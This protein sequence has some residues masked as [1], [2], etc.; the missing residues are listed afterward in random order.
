MTKYPKIAW[1]SAITPS[2]QEHY[3]KLLKS[4]VNDIIVCLHISGFG[5]YK[6]GE[7]H[8]VLA[9]GAGLH[10]QPCLS[11]D[12]SSPALDI[13]YFFALFTKLGYTQN[14][15]ITIRLLPNSRVKNKK[16]QLQR[17]IGYLS[18][19]VPEHHLG[20]AVDKKDIDSG[21]FKLEEIPISLN[22]TS[23][24]TKRLN[25][26][27][28]RAGTWFY[29]NEFDDEIQPIGYD[30]YG[31]YTGNTEVQ[32]S[33]DNIYIARPGDTWVTI[34]TRYGIWLPKLLELNDAKY[35]TLVVPGQE[36][37]LA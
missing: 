4:G 25:S 12:L 31:F 30:F 14:S 16:Q 5:K 13:K 7:Y 27:I 37:K 18:C 32:L 2:S 21:E 8:T 15:K 20:V 22:F 26:G 19:I 35:E 24:N 9:R 6:A 23:F 11:S 1:A 34:A 3:Q 10:T 36:I 33:L 17:L 29:T 28:D